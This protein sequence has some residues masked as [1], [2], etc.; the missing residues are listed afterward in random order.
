MRRRR[1]GPGV[2]L[3]SVGISI[4]LLGLM[5]LLAIPAAKELDLKE[6]VNEGVAPGNKR[7]VSVV[8]GGAAGAMIGGALALAGWALVRKRR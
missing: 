4:A 5:T 3:I 6:A 1:N 8:R 7:Q 2:F